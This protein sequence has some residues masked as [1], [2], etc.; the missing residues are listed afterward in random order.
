MSLFFNFVSV[1]IDT[2]ANVASLLFT[3]RGSMDW[4][5]GFHMVSGHS[6][7]YGCSP[8]LHLHHGSRHD[9]WRQPR[10]QASS[11]PQVAAQDTH[12]QVAPHAQQHDPRTSHVFSLQHK[13]WAFNVCVAVGSNRCHRHQ[14][15]TQ[16]QQDPG[17]RHSL[18]WLGVGELVLKL[19]DCFIC[20]FSV[21]LSLQGVL[22]TKS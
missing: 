7:D 14:H 12:H 9:P 3:L 2:T 15:K 8:W 1:T 21:Q 10:I 16:L 18:Q 6:A 20:V 17:C 22:W 5:M 4:I 11:W 13:P 19:S